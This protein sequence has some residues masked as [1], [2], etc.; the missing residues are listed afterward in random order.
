[1]PK[2]L[3]EAFQPH[4]ETALPRAMEQVFFGARGLTRRRCQSGRA[5]LTTW[6]AGDF[7]KDNVVANLRRLE[8]VH[9]AGS[10]KVLLGKDPDNEWPDH[11]TTAKTRT[12]ATTTST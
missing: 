2:A 5:R 12:R 9:Q 1:M 4:V 7:S 3:K 8:R 10:K 11:P 6:L